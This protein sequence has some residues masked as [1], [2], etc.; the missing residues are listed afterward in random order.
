M[1]GFVVFLAGCAVL[2]PPESATFLVRA[3]H[4]PG[5]NVDTDPPAL[6]EPNN[7][8]DVQVVVMLADGSGTVVAEGLTD[9]DGRVFLEVPSGGTYFIV[10]RDVEG[11]RTPERLLLDVLSGGRTET[12]L[13][14]T[15]GFR[16]DNDGH[17]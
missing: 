17:P 5:C 15:S 12:T 16:R 4:W 1:L 11:L 3:M 9:H 10:G 13:N 8:S 2:V 14:Y 6:C 7:V